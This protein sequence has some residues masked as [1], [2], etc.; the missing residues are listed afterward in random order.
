MQ[1]TTVAILGA[2]MSGI[3]MAIKLREA[4]ITDLVIL[5]KADSAGGTWHDNTYPGACCDVASHLYSFSFEPKPD[6]SR[7]FSPQQEIQHYFEHCVDK[8][9]L[10]PSIRYN[11]EVVAARLDEAAGEW[12]LT[13][14]DGEL[15]RC[16]MLVSGLGQ[17]N[18]PNTPAFAG[19]DSFRGDSFHSARWNHEV[20]LRGKRVAV[21]G[22]A[23]SA[24]QFI[25]PVAEQ[26]EHVY[27]YQRSANYIVPR[28]D[29]SYP[30]SEQQ[31]YRD[32]PWL[33]KLSRLRWYLRQELLMFGAM[34]P[35]SLRH[36][37]VSMGAKRY[38]EEQISDPGL[39][40]KLTPDYPLGCKRVLVSDD[41]YQALAKGGID[42]I[43]SP[44]QSIGES[45]VNT[46][47]GEDR[48][49]DVIIY[50]TGFRATEFLAPLQIQG[51]DGQLLNDSWRD[52]A[53]ALRGVAV[54]A[55]PNLF[56][57]YGPNTN[58]GHNS[59]IFMVESQV[60]YIVR[61]IDK[62]LAHD[63]RL[64]EANAE[65]AADFNETLQRDLADTVWG[66][67]CGSW[68]KNDQG[69]I[70]NNWP[71]SSLRFRWSMRS[72]D[73]TEYDMSV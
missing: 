15:L 4:D 17:L 13:L 5:E 21:I 42:I 67:E 16:R 72:P 52:G 66:G 32:H 51:R 26:A 33:L 60:K 28:N 47:D 11:T 59:I 10:G 63:I 31:R 46:E 49:V 8:Y 71:H 19:R 3:C 65:V 62:M 14:S 35:G 38:R 44:I 48:P 50:G 7:A 70:I 6:W 61:C 1:R 56:M 43:T 27:V 69:K 23:A 18:L 9:E 22:N 34:L 54:P 24:I 36:R 29:R 57:L 30:E 55:F 58:L 68:Y 39:R 45:G 53:W 40:A 2:G 73:F 25:P 41:Y 12:E 64:L 37:L 20:D